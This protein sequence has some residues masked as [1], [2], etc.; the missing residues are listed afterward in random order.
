[1]KSEGEAMLRQTCD[2]P[3]GE[4]AFHDEPGAH[5]PCY[6]V[7]P[8][9]AMLPLNHHA[10]EGVDIARAKFIVDACNAAL[11]AAPGPPLSSQ[12]SQP[13]ENTEE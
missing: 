6:V 12:V 5:D 3:V 13:T 4:F 11:R 8:G 2:W 9:G 7:M 1:M 10:G